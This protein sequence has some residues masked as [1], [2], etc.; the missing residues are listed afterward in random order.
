MGSSKSNT[1]GYSGKGGTYNGGTP[2]S[3]TKGTQS[4]TSGTKKK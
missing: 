4:G 2:S 3:G 1:G